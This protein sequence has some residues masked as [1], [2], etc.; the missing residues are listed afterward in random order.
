MAYSQQFVLPGK[1][2]TMSGDEEKN[3]K[4]YQNAKTRVLKNRASIRINHGRD[5]GIIR[6][7]VKQMINTLG[8]QWIK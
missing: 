4:A 2:I 6:L 3:D 5:V 7:D 8:L 1:T